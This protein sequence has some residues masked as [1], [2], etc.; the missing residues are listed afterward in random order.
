MKRTIFPAVAAA[1]ACL[2]LI[3]YN[4]YNDTNNQETAAAG[5][6]SAND[7]I[8]DWRND[9]DIGKVQPGHY[10]LIGI[11]E[12]GMTYEELLKLQETEDQGFLIINADGTAMLDIDGK[13]TEYIYDEYNLYFSDDTAGTD[14]IPYVFIGGRL[15]VD[16][17][18]TITQYL[19]LTDEEL[20]SYPEN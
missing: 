5:S 2:T 10:K 14:G 15:L 11:V 19:K 20:E 8:I 9:P 3:S 6:V 17:G 16:D 13:K 12:E 7:D 18:S 4:W 1:F